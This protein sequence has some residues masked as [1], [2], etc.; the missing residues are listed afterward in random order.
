MDNQPD[1]KDTGP[2]PKNLLLPYVVVVAIFLLFYIFFYQA[3]PREPS[4]EIP[5]SEFKAYL[6]EDRIDKITMQ[7]DALQGMFFE[8]QSIG[9]KG[10]KSQRFSTRIPSFGDDSLLP[11]LEQHRVQVQVKKPAGDSVGG[12]N[13]FSALLPWLIFFLI[14]FWLIRR[15][16]KRMGGGIGG[17]SE[18]KRFLETP[19]KEAKIPEI[20]FADVAGQEN[21][22]REVT[23]L[24]DYL[25]FPAK[26]LSLGAE[27]PR[28]VLLMGPPGTGKTL[29]AKAL[30]GEAGVPF[31]SISASEFI[32]VFVGVGASRVRNLF[33]EAKKHAP[34]IIFIDELDS[35]GR[36]RG[37]GLGGGHDE[38]EQTLNQI[39]AEMDGFSGHEAVIVLAATNRP[40]VLDS[41]LL[42]PG[43]FD[44]HVMLDLPDRKDRTAILRV[45]AKKV[46]LGGD[47]DLE[48]VAAGTPGFSGADLKNLV[49]EAAI[50]AARENSN[51]V[52]MQH[53]DAARDKVIMGTER[54]LVIEPDE[55]HRLAVH[56][57][58]HALVAYFV[59]H[60]DALYKVSIVPRGRS[61]GATQQLPEHERHTMPEDYLKDRLAVMLGGRTAEKEL[62]GT[63]S[64]G[65]DDD[66]HQATRLARAMV[67]RWGM[68]EDIGPVDL[69]ESEEHPF[70]GREIAQ[71]RHYS[72]HSAEAVDDAVKKIIMDAED[73]ALQTIRQHRAKLETLIQLLEKRETL[74]KEQIVMCLGVTEN[75][76]D[77]NNT[78]KVKNGHKTKE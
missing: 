39:L 59:P 70:L 12:I 69:R 11:A 19:H 33:D 78:E 42:R 46:P 55:K 58:G 76:T 65:A 27:I 53:F 48:K 67:A 3:A 72:E 10:E 26:Y 18:L 6:E 71:P 25:R 7:G 13:Y 36:T 5:Y 29:L 20:T 15:A 74:Y 38:R 41:A 28:G 73:H 30:A 22:K 47:V 68:S 21:A 66:I 54:T 4:Y 40:D 34:S 75:V 2:S 9:P 49:N 52:M 50:N 61:L 77:K 45:H 31:Y 17:P 57:A 16:S 62:I 8:E 24:V 56:E 64:S 63:V 60:A 43:R 35:V 23:E 44:R 51:T 37:A 14:F 1:P 32:E